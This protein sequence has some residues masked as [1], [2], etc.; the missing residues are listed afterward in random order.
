MS[1]DIDVSF[2]MTV[3]NKEYYLPSVLKA[4][5]NQTSV[6][7]PEYIFVDDNSTDKSVEIIKNATKGV[8]NVTI[9]VN[10]ENLGISPNTNK[11]IKEAKGEYVR[12]LDSDDIFPIDSTEKMLK[13]ARTHNADMVYGNF[14]KT[15]MEPQLL[16]NIKMENFKY[17]YSKDALMLTLTSNFVRMGQ[18][19]KTSVLKNS[20]GADERVFIQDQSLPIR[21]AMHAKGAIKLNANVVLVPKEIGNFSGNKLQL[22]HDRFLACAYAIIDNPKLDSKYLK[23]LYQKAVSAYWKL[24]R[25]SS[26]LPY[27][28]DHFFLYVWNR[29]LPDVPDMEYLKMMK[30]T[31]L[32]IKGIRRT[33]QNVEFELKNAKKK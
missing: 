26:K 6:K 15:K 24:I 23:I 2:V 4:L 9:I 3:Y 28:D 17:K 7:N 27:W 5:L 18:L 22:D 1:D 14:V 30:D 32:R 10:K 19:I 8:K 33:P 25:K 13:L 21:A 29:M 20:Q 11:A 12:L 16:T 31:F